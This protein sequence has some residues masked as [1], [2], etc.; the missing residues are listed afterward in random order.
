[1]NQRQRLISALTHLVVLLGVSWG[2]FHVLIPPL[3]SAGAWFYAG[4]ATLLLAAALTEPF[5]ARPADAVANGVA[6]VLIA[7][8]YSASVGRVEGASASAINS[9]K[10]LLV[11]YGALVAALG[12]IAIV[13]KDGRYASVSERVSR[14]C[15]T[16]GSGR[17]VYSCVYL[18]S[19]YA[20]YSR[21]PSTLGVLLTTW[22]VIVVIRPGD[23]VATLFLN[24]ERRE[25][26][27]ATVVGVRTP[28][29]V[30]VSAPVATRLQPGD[31]LRFEAQTDGV[32]LDVSANESGI[33]SLVSVGG[34]RPGTKGRPALDGADPLVG[35]VAVVPDGGGPGRSRGLRHPRDRAGD[36]Q[37]VPRHLPLDQGADV[38]RGPVGR[39]ARSMPT[40][41]DVRAAGHHGNIPDA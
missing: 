7:V 5:F 17:V 38:R 27:R 8:T 12:I 40:C 3:G 29:L 16:F 34:D 36:P 35:G 15:R 22:L 31:V 23:W 24:R 39:R 32:V 41:A 6:A 28:G 2:L 10:L 26:A 11:A 9:G 25:H 21:S 30:E 20:T 33:W 37:T 14:Y 1:M 4:I 19:V 13:T 18:F